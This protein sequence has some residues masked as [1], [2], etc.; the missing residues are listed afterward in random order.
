MQHTVRAHPDLFPFP[1]DKG[2]LRTETPILAYVSRLQSLGAIPRVSLR[3]VKRRR[4]GPDLFRSEETNDR[5]LL[6]AQQPR[7]G[8]PDVAIKYSS[9]SLVPPKNT[10]T[11]QPGFHNTEVASCEVYVNGR[12]QLGD[13]WHNNG[14]ELQMVADHQGT[15]QSSRAGLALTCGPF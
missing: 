3:P 15:P 4:G 7:V 1:L 11:S 5:R 8:Q 13:S 14:S 9:P 6:A 2:I 12:P 10:A